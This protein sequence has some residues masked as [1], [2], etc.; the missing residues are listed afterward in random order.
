[1]ADQNVPVQALATALSVTELLDERAGAGVT[2]IADELDRSKSA[3]HNHL[4]T[5]EQLGYVVKEGTTYRLGPRF[6]ELGLRVRNRTDVYGAARREL[7]NLARATGEMATLLVED[8]GDGVFLYVTGAENVESNPEGRR[9]SLHSTST[10]KAILA[11][12][13]RVEVLEIVD[14]RGLPERTEHTI[15]DRDELLSELRTIRERGIAFGREE[16]ELGRSGVAA[17]I[18][19]EDERAVGAISVSGPA[20][21]MSGKR[22]EEDVTGLVVSAA[23]AIEVQLTSN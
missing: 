16:H 10:G 9:V 22:L 7:D 11:N 12:R 23:K 15:T 3:V 2:E 6:L 5:L 17:P 21:S 8:D 20:N 13:P 4:N 14:D 1:M 19:D 18:T